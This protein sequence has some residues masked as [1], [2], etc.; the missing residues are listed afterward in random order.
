[1][2]IIFYNESRRE[3][4]ELLRGLKIFCEKVN[5]LN[6]ISFMEFR[7]NICRIVNKN[8]FNDSTR[9]FHTRL[10]IE[11]YSFIFVRTLQLVRMKCTYK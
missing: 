8:F 11:Q 1:M 10:N 2:E 9:V 5:F 3:Y 7:Y 6:D 4:T